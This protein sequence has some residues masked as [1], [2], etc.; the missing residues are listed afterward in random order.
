MSHF[1][2]FPSS[3]RVC[4]LE[5]SGVPVQAYAL[6]RF[7]TAHPLD[8]SDHKEPSQCKRHIPFRVGSGFAILDKMLACFLPCRRLLGVFEGSNSE[9]SIS[10]EGLRKGYTPKPY[11]MVFEPPGIMMIS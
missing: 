1:F 7:S 11:I 8:L 2:R 9:P 6:V 10:V 4:V 5:S 3:P